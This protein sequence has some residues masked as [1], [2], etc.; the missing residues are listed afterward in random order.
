MS[1]Q[2]P[3]SSPK[4]IPEYDDLDATA[5]AE[6]I[7]NKELSASE[8]L[9]AAIERA[10]LRNPS[11]NAI[12][13][14]LYERAR[15]Q[16]KDLPD[17]PLSGVPF[18]LK[19]LKAQLKGTPTSNGT[20]LEKGRIAEGNSL[21]V[22]RFL[23][24]GV[25]VMGKS[26]SPEFGIMGV[27]EPKIWGPCR[28]PWDLNRTPGGSSGGTSS[29]VAA[30]IVPIAH[31]G[32]GGGSIRIP[33]SATGTFGLKPTR[34]RVSMAPYVGEGWGGFVQEGVITRSV[35]D[36]ALALDQIDQLTIGEPY[37]APHKPHPW[38]S[39]LR[40]PDR[41]LKV[42]YI[43]STLFGQENHPDCVAAVESSVKLLDELGHHV[44]EAMPSFPRDELVEAYFM[45]VASG[46]SVFVENTS[47]YAGVKPSV[48]NFET[49]TWAL[50]Q[51]GWHTSAARLAR[52]R[53]TIHRASR[54]IAQFFSEYDLFVTSTHAAPPV[55]IGEL[56][57]KTADKLQLA[58]IRNLPLQS[59]FD[60]MLKGMGN[61]ALSKTP[62]TMLFNQTG[63]PGM[64][65]PLHWND[66]DLPIGT[67][68]IAPFGGEGLL[69]QV[70]T[71]LEEARPWAH[72]HPP[73]IKS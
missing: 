43:T 23:A 52:A 41:K 46:T 8:V 57:L 44:E 42:A 29:A 18:L 22:D 14:P 11:L 30:R 31:A 32:D 1:N 58:L 4:I 34:G 20:K 48:K 62:N 35:R 33:A 73:F 63:Q 37:A 69:F 68:V 39:Y 64:S 5:L 40:V 67:Q 70:A 19:D 71:Q 12:V 26:N 50:A 49:I 2:Q 53:D 16:A 21:I 54:Q 15:T 10:E 27:T 6:L 17:G 28:N 13:T 24:S 7:K 45:I 51:I 9:E 66:D 3:V 38:T 60:L 65:I 61:K 55:M 47:A 56:G 36:S 59:L 72:R 25:Q